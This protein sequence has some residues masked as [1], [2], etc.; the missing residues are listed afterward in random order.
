MS[1]AQYIYNNSLHVFSKLIFFEII[2]DYRDDFVSKLDDKNCLDVSAFRER[3]AQLW[4]ER[5]RLIK[6]LRSVQETQARYHDKKTISRTFQLENKIMLSIKNL[7]NARSKK[8]LFYK[9]I[10]SFEVVDVMSAQTYRLRLFEKWRIHFVF[11]VSLLKSYHENASITKSKNMKLAD[12]NE[13]YEVE[14]IL[15]NKT[16]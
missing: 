6:R 9:F 13:K 1:I 3:I 4:N 15:N 12:E 5:D 7:K 10:G 16:K 14:T 11:H 8:K 2:Y